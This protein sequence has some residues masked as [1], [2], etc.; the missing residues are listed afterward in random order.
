MKTVTCAVPETATSAVAID[1][2]SCV[3]LTNVVPRSVPF[4]RTTED[5]VNPLPFTVRLNGGAPAG[6][7]E[8]ASDVTTGAPGVTVTVGLVAARV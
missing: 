2:R 6:D 3:L 1:A 5:D 4:H 8:G 7:A